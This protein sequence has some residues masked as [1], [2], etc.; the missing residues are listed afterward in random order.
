MT[1]AEGN[2]NDWRVMKLFHARNKPAGD[3]IP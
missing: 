3:T 1:F 2:P